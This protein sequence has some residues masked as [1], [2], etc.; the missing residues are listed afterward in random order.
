[1]EA[2][3]P[4]WIRAF[5]LT[6]LLCSASP[7][8][9]QPYPGPPADGRTYWEVPAFKEHPYAGPEKARG[10]I[11]W[12]HGL[13][14]KNPQWQGAPPDIIRDAAGAGWDVMKVNR[15]SLHETSWVD[16]GRKHVAHVVSLGQKAKAD[17]YRRIVAAGQSY[18]GAI[19]IEAAAAAPDLFHGIFASGPGHGSDSCFGGPSLTTSQGLVP[20]LTRAI[21]A[22]RAQRTVLLMAP[23]DACQGINRPTSPI[24]TALQSTGRPFVFL[25]DSIAVAG[26]G[27]VYTAQF[28]AWYRTCFLD[29][30]AKETVAAGETTCL[31]PSPLPEF[32][33]PANVNLGAPDAD[34]SGL[35]GWWRGTFEEITSTQISTSN[36]IFVADTTGQAVCLAVAASPA[37]KVTATMYWGNGRKRTLSM[38]SGRFEFARDGQ[39]YA[40]IGGGEYRFQLT[41]EAD[42][43]RM[44]F[45]IRSRDGVNTFYGS[46][47]RLPGRC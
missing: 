47:Q 25:D 27:A 35:T 23:G 21:E 26:H 12:S 37:E 20:L 6:A 13:N 11:I 43:K 34:R 38:V 36:Q 42:G 16:S 44:R 29:F 41:P 45:T 4:P 46:L 10:L 3:V 30:L 39:R 5:F 24:R 14:G 19:S 15:N 31:A 18:G 9:A 28:R 33:I 8:L 2:M 7:I 17:G 22:H 1:M 40:H 32:L